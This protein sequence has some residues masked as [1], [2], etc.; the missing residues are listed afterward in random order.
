ML[1]K[2]IRPPSIQRLLHSGYCLPPKQSLSRNFLG[3]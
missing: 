1:F 3:K 2:Y